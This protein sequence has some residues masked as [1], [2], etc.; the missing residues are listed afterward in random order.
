LWLF[1]DRGAPAQLP[2]ISHLQIAIGN[3]TGQWLFT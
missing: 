2:T 3:S 1:S